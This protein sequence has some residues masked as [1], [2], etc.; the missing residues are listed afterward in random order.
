MQFCSSMNPQYPIA[1]LQNTQ[2]CFFAFCNYVIMQSMNPSASDR[3]DKLHCSVA[4]RLRVEI[5]SVPKGLCAK[6]IG[7][8]M[9]ALGL[10]VH[11][12]CT[13]WDLHSTKL[14][15]CALHKLGLGWPISPTVLNTDIAL[16][17]IIKVRNPMTILPRPQC[18]KRCCL[19]APE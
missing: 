5:G 13:F 10:V 4:C 19:V 15:S 14:C 2:F 16:E 7:N 3:T 11:F 17:V 18:L 12:H 9:R 6:H 1:Q 8:N